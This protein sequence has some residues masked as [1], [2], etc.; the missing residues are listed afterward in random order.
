MGKVYE[1]LSEKH[2]TFIRNQH[3]FFV[4]TAP[5]SEVG[6]VNCSP[7]GLDD[8]FQIIDEQRVAYLDLTGSG[9]ETIAHLKE[10]ARMCLM[11]CAFQGPPNIVRLYGKGVSHEPHQ[12][13]FSELIERFPTLPGTRAII[14]LEITRVQDSCGFSVPLYTYEG[15]RDTLIKYAEKKGPAGMVEYRERKNRFSIDQLP[16]LDI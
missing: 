8:T 2:Q 11:F 9:V 5:L 4:A 13:R 12:A 7:K 10:N 6:H 14:E 16:G 1:A 3:M 15:Q